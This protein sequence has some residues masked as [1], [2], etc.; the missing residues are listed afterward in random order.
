MPS[1]GQKIIAEESA[2]KDTIGRLRAMSDEDLMTA[3]GMKSELTRMREVL[4]KADALKGEK[5]T[6]VNNRLDER[7]NPK[8]S[9]YD[10][11]YL[12]DQKDGPSPGCC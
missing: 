3:M 9:T 6:K 12:V 11:D 1:L 8:V 2:T 7:M 10:I 4:D 5:R